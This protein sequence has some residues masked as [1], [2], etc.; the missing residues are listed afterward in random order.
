MTTYSYTPKRVCARNITF[1]IEEGRLHDISFEGGCDGNLKAIS[2]LLEGAE[3]QETAEI[4]RGN[5][6]RGRGT[7]CADQLAQ[8]IEEVL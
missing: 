2:T 6:C 5:D 4:L 3:A 1:S 8:A 7:S